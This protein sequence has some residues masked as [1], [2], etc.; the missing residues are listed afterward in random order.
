MQV[1][2]EHPVDDPERR[3]VQR[4]NVQKVSDLHGQ[5][6]QFQAEDDRVH[7]GHAARVRRVRELRRFLQ[8]TQL[9]FEREIVDS[10]VATVVHRFD[11]GPLLD[12]FVL[13]ADVGSVVVAGSSGSSDSSSPLPPPPPS[14]R[15]ELHVS[16]LYHHELD[17]MQLL[18]LR[19]AVSHDVHRRVQRQQD[20]VGRQEQQHVPQ[21][22][23]EEE[24]HAPHRRDGV[25]RQH[26]QEEAEGARTGRFPAL[27]R[28]VRGGSREV[29]EAPQK[30]QH[31]VPQ[32]QYEE[33]D[34][35]RLEH[36]RHEEELEQQ[37]SPEALPSRA[38]ASGGV[39]LQRVVHG[40]RTGI[41]VGGVDSR[42]GNVDGSEE[43]VR[44]G[45]VEEVRHGEEEVGDGDQSR[46][47]GEYL[48]DDGAE[49]GASWTRWGGGRDR[50]SGWVVA[51]VVVVVIPRVGVRCRRRNLGRHS[52]AHVGIGQK[53]REQGRT[54]HAQHGGEQGVQSDVGDVDHAS[55]ILL[56]SLLLLR[57]VV[58]ALAAAIGRFVR[59][60]SIP[61]FR[62]DRPPRGGW[63]YA[64]RRFGSRHSGGGMGGG[65]HGLRRGELGH[66]QGRME[67]V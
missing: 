23:R 38:T 42:G 59:L 17:P 10:I 58:F 4:P 62:S 50:L 31:G 9:S 32:E 39:I 26:Q 33:V 41:V 7:R 44:H 51:V 64:R 63:R 18:Q 57:R 14:Q 19:H 34:A 29:G 5:R 54:H 22:R 66:G 11:V 6:V 46:S 25:N 35:V 56:R 30:R 47:G 43:D 53:R 3:P 24:R 28:V 61:P 2:R 8:V 49:F 37:E 20:A 16:I 36:R 52:V 13:V 48:I 12:A 67:L 60:L 21:P 15:A 45:G 27:T 1:Q 65:C 55:V 40:D